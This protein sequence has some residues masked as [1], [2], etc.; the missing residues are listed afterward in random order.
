M[1]I[2]EKADKYA[3]GKANEAITKAIAQAYMDGYRDGY[4]DCEQEIPEDLRENGV[5]YVDLGLPSGTLW[6]SDYLKE[7]DEIVYLPYGKAEKMNIPTKEQ[8]EE[9]YSKC[10][11]VRGNDNHGRYVYVVGRNGN[12]IRFRQTNILKGDQL[13]NG[14][15]VRVWLKDEEEEGNDKLNTFYR[16]EGNG[17]VFEDRH[18]FSGFGFPIRLVR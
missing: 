12:K 8:W 9:L 18:V 7:D 15:G 14:Y 5:E 3:E 10:Q 2:S 17:T 6:S 1:N 4:N 11:W 16:L 13:E